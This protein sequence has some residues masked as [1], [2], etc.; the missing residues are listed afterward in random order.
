MGLKTTVD[1]LVVG[2][3]TATD[4]AVPR[5]DGATGKLI[6]DS[7]ITITDA[8][9]LTGDGSGLTG[10]SGGGDVVGPASSVDNRLVRWDG[11]TGKLIQD[12]GSITVSDSG[13]ILGCTAFTV[14]SL[15][16]DLNQITTPENT[17]L[18]LTTT[19][20]GDLNFNGVTIDPSSNI[21]SATGDL[22]LSAG[23]IEAV[24]PSSGVGYLA[25]GASGTAS[26]GFRVKQ[27]VIDTS[28][29]ID[30]YEEGATRKGWLGFG[31]SNP[32]TLFAIVN[33][34]SDG[35][36][37][38][39]PGG[40]TGLRTIELNAFTQLGSD[41]ASVPKIKMKKLTGTTGATEGSRVTVAHGLTGAKIL[42]IDC[43]ILWATNS[44][45]GPGHIY[46]VGYNYSCY[47]DNVN[48]N[49][50]LDATGSENVT[51]KEYTVLI[52]YEA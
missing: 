8:G 21:V 30:F 26:V 45:M 46:D 16:L 20:T 10:V 1:F 24:I 25:L 6:Q 39:A 33:D 31:S 44:K 43:L 18:W 12:N 47:A 15:F 11:V 41:A 23:K 3:L 5:F 48:I 22:T 38:I 28:T 40:Q 50:R 29:I 51:S 27:G 42:A 34:Y 9:V 37:K 17:D 14:D 19:G 7:G 13:I 4:N 2:P 35:D 32:R 36:I 52:T 49:V